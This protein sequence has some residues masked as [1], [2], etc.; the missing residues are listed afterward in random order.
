M[1]EH[2]TT[3]R[4]LHALVAAMALTGVGIETVLAV[5]AGPETELAQRLARGVSYFTIQSNLLV[6]L[7][8]AML[9]A[10]PARDGRVF[11]V[12]RLDSVVCASLTGILYHAGIGT[13][14]HPSI[15]SA[16]SDTLLHTAVPVATVLV[17]FAVGPRARLGW[18][19]LGWAL[20]LPL[21]YAGSISVAGLL[22]A[23][24]PYPFLDVARVGA[25]AVVTNVDAV[26]VL[27]L[28][29]GA[30]VRGVERVLTTAWSTG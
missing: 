22:S 16:I 12:I 25:A 23:W 17:W 26:V 14:R 6:A 10:R 15:A 1:T 4:V 9:A 30:A 21:G 11:R 29:L 3:A 24:Y 28:V 7:V 19:D 27:F 13:L 5:A 2:Q 20:V 8:S 18:H